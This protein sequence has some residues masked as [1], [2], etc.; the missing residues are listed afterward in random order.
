[1]SHSNHLFDILQTIKDTINQQIPAAEI[2]HIKHRRTLDGI[3]HQHQ[4][5][6]AIGQIHE[7]K[8]I[9]LCPRSMAY[10]G[11]SHKD[12]RTFS[13]ADYYHLLHKDYLPMIFTITE[14]FKTKPDEFIDE[15]FKV[16]RHDNAYQPIYAIGTSLYDEP[17]HLGNIII[18]LFCDVTELIEKES[19]TSG[20]AASLSMNADALKKYNS[21]T[22]RE[23]E[24]LRWI[25]LQKINK[26]IADIMYISIHTVEEHRK[27]LMKKLGVNNAAGLAAFAA[28]V[29]LV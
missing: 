21:L 19:N 16:K 28:R 15:T 29:G 14:H 10:M 3:I 12:L 24:V 18:A 23:I 27:N 2:A 8:P 11:L 26:E 4:C 7:Q 13:I 5:Y 20:N 17:P 22:P 1:M 6:I 9:Y 25:G